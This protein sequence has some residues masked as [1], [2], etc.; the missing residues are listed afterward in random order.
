LFLLFGDLLVVGRF[1]G[2]HIERE[3]R[4]CFLRRNRRIAT[5]GG[6]VAYE[7]HQFGEP[8]AAGRFQI[9]RHRCVGERCAE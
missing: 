5:R 9:I 3:N 6:T 8:R 2:T 1:R 7:R 4:K